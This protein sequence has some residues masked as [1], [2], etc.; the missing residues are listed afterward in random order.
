MRELKKE[1]VEFLDVFNNVTVPNL[2][3]QGFEANAINAREGLLNTTYTCT[4][5]QTEVKKVMDGTVKSKNGEYNVP[6]RIFDP[7]PEK[8]LPVLIYFHGGGHM[9]G[10]VTVYNEVIR[11]LA[12]ET[13]HIVVAPEFRL[14]PENAYP[15]QEIDSRTVYYN[16]FDIL[17]E[18]KIKYQKKL[19]FGGDSGGGA[20]TACLARDIQHDSDDYKADAI[21]MIYP[22][23][24]YT[25]SFDSYKDDVNGK[26]YLLETPKIKW[27]FDNYFQHG[28]D[29]QQASPL[30]NE[31]TNGIP[32][33]I[34]FTAEFCPLRDEGYAYVEKL[35]EAG[36]E[37]V[38]HNMENMIH[39][40]MSMQDLAKEEADFTYQEI[41]K[42]L[43]R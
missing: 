36:V 39:T 34:I 2:V 8:E 3:A 10:S 41:N 32:R 17:D 7:D 37:V 23:L 29:R 13:N 1:M 14:A 30:Y 43:N 5:S 18:K 38:H 27:Y 33:T 4:T 21:F 25:M 20:L 31:I 40:Y 22:S 11:R 16:V 12:V 35:K 19:R 24:D 26:G 42:F 28:E 15:A 6:V 9:A